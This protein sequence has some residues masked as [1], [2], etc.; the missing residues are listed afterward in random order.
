MTE[1]TNK[2]NRIHA[3]DARLVN[4]IAAGEIIERPASMLKEL[5]ENSLD[6]GATS[7]E[8]DV[9]NAG[10]KRL[11]ICLLYTSPSPRDKRQSRMPSSA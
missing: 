11:K 10:V 1:Q 5:I 6:A 8:V 3:L 2:P 9:E 4:Q 7:I